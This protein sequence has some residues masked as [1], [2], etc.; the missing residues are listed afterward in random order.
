[1]A[2]NSDDETLE[3]MILHCKAWSKTR[4]QIL[5]TIV[6]L[7]AEGE[8]VIW[9]DGGVGFFSYEQFRGTDRYVMDIPTVDCCLHQVVLNIVTLRM[10]FNL[11]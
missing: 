2:C 5:P 6:R 3:H 10:K 8:N 11:V 1:M 9:S 4:E 7:L